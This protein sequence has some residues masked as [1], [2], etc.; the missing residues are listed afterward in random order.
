MAVAAKNAQKLATPPPPLP[1]RVPK[2]KSLIEL[3]TQ[4]NTAPAQSPLQTARKSFFSSASSMMTATA[5]PSSIPAPP[6]RGKSIAEQRKPS[7]TTR[8]PRTLSQRVSNMALGALQR[9]P[10][11]TPKLES[12]SSRRTSILG[13]VLRRASSSEEE[14]DAG[15]RRSQ[16]LAGQNN[17]SDRQLSMR[18]S[19]AKGAGS[20]QNMA[21]PRKKSETVFTKKE[22]KS[23]RMAATESKGINWDEDES[24]TSDDT[25]SLYSGA[26][27]DPKKRPTLVINMDA[28][29]KQK[30]QQGNSSSRQRNGSFEMVNPQHD[31]HAAQFGMMIFS[32]GHALIEE[33][34]ED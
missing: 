18:L 11:A 14:D 34:D 9:R 13:S 30:D 26:E 8:D 1:A 12:S 32:A 10:S 21:R 27:D 29:Y 31:T 19:F 20:E 28:M 17:N 5:S 6:S 22:M 15:K 16:M 23:I 2:K 4:Q 25:T 33:E 3:P 24:R 7:I